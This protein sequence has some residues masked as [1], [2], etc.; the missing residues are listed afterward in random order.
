M[1]KR[2]NYTQTTN[3][4]VLNTML[5]KDETQIKNLLIYFRA[6]QGTIKNNSI[7]H[8]LDND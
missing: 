6:D 8:I 2:Q 4:Y 5:Y 1:I 7:A 3:I